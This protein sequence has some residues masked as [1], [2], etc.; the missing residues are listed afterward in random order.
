MSKITPFLPYYIAPPNKFIRY[1]QKRFD[2]GAGHAATLNIAV[3][4]N[5]HKEIVEAVAQV[6]WDNI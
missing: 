2:D 1:Y 4:E 3:Y 5:K 6:I